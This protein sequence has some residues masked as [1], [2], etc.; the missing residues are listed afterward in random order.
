LHD[1]FWQRQAAYCCFVLAVSRTAFPEGP[2]TAP[3]RIC[4]ILLTLNQRFRFSLETL[5]G[6]AQTSIERSQ[7]YSKRVIPFLARNARANALFTFQGQDLSDQIVATA[8]KNML[9]F[10]LYINTN[11]WERQGLYLIFI[12]KFRPVHISGPDA[13]T[14][15]IFYPFQDSFIRTKTGAAAK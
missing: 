6:C 15:V 10:S 3:V 14:I 2:K 1:L 8:L 12:Q 5:S 9:S 4:H 7:T 13:V 11:S